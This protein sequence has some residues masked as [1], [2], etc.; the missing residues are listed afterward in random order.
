MT[1]FP[2]VTPVVAAFAAVTVV[3]LGVA[4]PTTASAATVSPHSREAT[5][6]AGSGALSRAAVKPVPPYVPVRATGQPVPATPAGL[7]AAIDPLPEYQGQREC[8]PAPKPGALKLAN[9]L[10]ATYGSTDI[11]IDRACDDGGMARH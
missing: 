3:A 9:L 5:P 4:V 11:G 2:R 7:P 8:S 10:L 1:P 6:V